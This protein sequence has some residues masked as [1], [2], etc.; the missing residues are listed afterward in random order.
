MAAHRILFA[1][2]AAALCALLPSRP[3]TRCEARC[4]AAAATDDLRRDGF[5]VVRGALPPALCARVRADLVAEYGSALAG[6]EA[7]RLTLPLPLDHA[8]MAAVRRLV[9]T[10][11]ALFVDVFGEEGSLRTLQ[12][13]VALPGAARQHI[14]ADIDVVPGLFYGNGFVALQDVTRDMGP[15]VFYPG[16]H[17]AAFHAARAAHTGRPATMCE[18]TRAPPGDPLAD[19]APAAMV[20]RAG[21]LVLFDACAHHQGTE[22]ASR[23]QRV[24]LQF[25]FL[26]GG[27][28]ARRLPGNIRFMASPD[29]AAGAVRVR[30]LLPVRG[31]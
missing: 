5:V 17:T 26:A 15:T 24:L 19:L 21:D 11:A 27:A 30:D 6:G 28:D 9:G 23:E 2:P 31:R 10:N 3:A 7:G 13:I 22:N 29:V 25:S 4:D 20:L 16:T 8:A 1:A 18:A 12:A 14:H